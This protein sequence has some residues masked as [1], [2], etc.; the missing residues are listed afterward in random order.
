ML[1][2]TTGIFMRANFA[3]SPLAALLLMTATVPASAKSACL[4]NGKAFKIGQTACLT[5][6][7]K[8]H[9]AQC[10]TELNNTS[11]VKTA[12]ACPQP[13]AASPQG[14]NPSS[15]PGKPQAGSDDPAKN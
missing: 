3:F 13:G 12:D 15:E 5:I 14:A 9:L 6:G 4:A 2:S 1:N 11:W 8:S 10:D 7:G